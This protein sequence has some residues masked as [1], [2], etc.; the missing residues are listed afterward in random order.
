MAPSPLSHRVGRRSGAP[1]ARDGV[2]IDLVL[3]DDWELR[4]DGSGS[5]RELQFVTLERLLEIYERY[6]LRA[7]INAEVLQQLAHRRFGT[8]HV[9]LQDVADEWDRVVI[10]AYS[11]GHDVQL[12]LHPQW[13]DASY[14]ERRW[15]LGGSWELPVYPP[16]DV[17][18]MLSRAKDYLEEL[19]HGAGHSGYRCVTFRSGGWAFAPSDH[20]IPALKE[21]GIQVDVSIA[22]GLYYN[23]PRVH[24]D[25]RGIDEPFLP[26]YPAPTD[27][28][29]LG[30]S[31]T[32]L[33][34]VPTHSFRANDPLRAAETDARRPPVRFSYRLGI[35][36]APR[37]ARIQMLRGTPF[38]RDRLAT[39]NAASESDS[40]TSTYAQENW[41][42]DVPLQTSVSDLSGMTYRQMKEMLRDIELRARRTGAPVV[43]IVLENHTKDIRDFRPLE[44]FAALVAATPSIRVITLSEL[45]RNLDAGAYPIRSAG[46]G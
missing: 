18:V 17:R 16:D 19:L 33:V 13:S 31:E 40:E 24:L 9:E 37:I 39:P 32:G 30:G 36:V 2:H 46:D 25:Y 44:R 22:D 35:R 8:E 7:S 20:I 21:L 29:R 45:A 41:T 6:E 3:S 26:Y 10:D 4:G 1:G 15:Q 5:V 28:R 38:C 34:C 27:A 12:H 42:P 23:G 43:P 11:R 14:E